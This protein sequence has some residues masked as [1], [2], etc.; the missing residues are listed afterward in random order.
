MAINLQKGQNVSLNKEA[1]GLNELHVGLG[2]DVQQ[3]AGA[4]FDLDVMVYLTG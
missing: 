3:F 1:P 4:D 2:W